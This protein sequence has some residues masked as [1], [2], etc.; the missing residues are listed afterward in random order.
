MKTHPFVFRP[1]GASAASALAAAAVCFLASSVLGAD[2]RA[3]KQDGKVKVPAE[4]RV[5]RD[6]AY[7]PAGQSAILNC[8]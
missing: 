5:E 7:L 2:L 8:I 1:A 3:W 6:V 4:V